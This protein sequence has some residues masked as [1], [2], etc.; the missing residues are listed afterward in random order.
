MMRDAGQCAAGAADSPAP[1]P[2][3]ERR[4]R[5]VRAAA[6]VLVASFVAA[7]TP[8]RADAA[9]EGAGSFHGPLAV[10][11]YHP[12][13]LPIYYLPIESPETPGDHRWRLTSTLAESNSLLDS[14]D[15]GGDTSLFGDLETSRLT[16]GAALGLGERAEITLEVPVIARW[17]GFLDPV[18]EAAERLADEFNPVRD[19]VPDNDVFLEYVRDGVS[20][21][22]FDDGAAGLGDVSLSGKLV[23]WRS[24]GGSDAL[25]LRAG[26]ELPTGDHSELFGSEGVDAGI[27]LAYRHAGSRTA[28][29]AHGSLIVPGEFHDGPGLAVD[30]FVTFAGGFEYLA[31]RRLAILTQLAYYESPF[32]GGGV[33]EMDQGLFELTAGVG[34][35]LSPELTLQIGGVENLVLRPAADFSLVISVMRTLGPPRDPSRAARRPV[36]VSTGGARP[37]AADAESEMEADEVEARAARGRRLRVGASRRVG[38]AGVVLDAGQSAEIDAAGTAG[39]GRDLAAHDV[40]DRAG[41]SGH[42][43]PRDDRALAAGDGHAGDVALDVEG[44]AP[45]L[46]V[47][48]ARL[49]VVVPRPVAGAES[50]L[51]VGPGRE[52]VIEP[53]GDGNPRGARPVR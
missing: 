41:A 3:Q 8:A 1:L 50:Q 24:R 26:L 22:A 42:L 6:I 11:Q 29:Y 53:E 52:Q 20:V 31:S 14:L 12:L 37:V 16:L 7:V 36:P 45:D 43:A 5:G 32:E 10:R 23:V 44:E 4:R 38:V 33:A 28:W 25:S 48:D 47:V 19:E 40:V 46:Q 30:P 27:A 34:I 35:A 21:L 13:H 2:R 51:D 39:Q 15:T 49:D 9:R 18:I 17:G